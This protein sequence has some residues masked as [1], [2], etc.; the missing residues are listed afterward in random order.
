MFALE[1]AWGTDVIWDG[2]MF[3]SCFADM[4]SMFETSEKEKQTFQKKVPASTLCTSPRLCLWAPARI[5]SSR[6]AHMHVKCK[7]TH[8]HVHLYFMVESSP[9]PASPTDPISHFIAVRVTKHWHRL[10]REAPCLE[11]LKS[12]LDVVLGSQLQMALLEQVAWTMGPPEVPSKLN[13]SVIPWFYVYL[14]H[15]MNCLSTDASQHQSY[16]SMSFCSSEIF[17]NLQSFLQQVWFYFFLFLLVPYFSSFQK[18]P[19]YTR[20]L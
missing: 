14:S 9:E 8:A 11:G 15:L 12:N 16:W 6:A 4:P 17:L 7:H 3:T 5:C 18:F 2:T 13:Q 19:L 10:P 1:I 20:I